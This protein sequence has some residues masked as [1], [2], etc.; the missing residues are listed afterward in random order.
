MALAASDGDS[1][2]SAAEEVIGAPLVSV[3]KHPTL[4][5][6]RGSLL[7]GRDA[8]SASSAGASIAAVS[9]GVF[10]LGLD[11]RL[12][13]DDEGLEKASFLRRRRRVLVVSGVVSASFV[14]GP[15]VVLSAGG[16]AF[17]PVFALLATAC[18]GVE[19]PE[20]VA[21]IGFPPGVALGMA[22]LND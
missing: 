7:C 8:W 6:A 21:F 2:S 20:L 11:E 4:G 15:P 13:F 18:L 22:L 19:R 5:G 17:F 16:T 10:S 12:D 9:S 3:A 1:G 14:P